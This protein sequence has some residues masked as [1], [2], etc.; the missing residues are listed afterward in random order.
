MITEKPTPQ[1]SAIEHDGEL[2]NDDTE[3]TDLFGEADKETDGES[4]V[5][6]DA[7]ESLGGDGSKKKG[8]VLEGLKK[9]L[10]GV[11]GAFGLFR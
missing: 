3:E 1:P 6:G 8:G 5:D 7:E 2:L 10:A 4:V 9:G 11:T